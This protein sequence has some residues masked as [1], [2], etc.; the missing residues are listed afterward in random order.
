MLATDHLMGRS[1][2]VVQTEPHPPYPT[3]AEYR[4]PTRARRFLDLGTTVSSV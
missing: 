3:L 2:L 1:T 4:T